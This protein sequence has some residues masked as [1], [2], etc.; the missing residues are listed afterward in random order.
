MLQVLDRRDLGSDPGSVNVVHV[1][2]NVDSN[3][4]EV[5][6]EGLLPIACWD[7]GFEIHWRHE[8]LFHVS[9]V[10]CQVE[11]SARGRSLDRGI[12]TDSFF[13][14]TKCCQEN[15]NLR[16]RWGPRAAEIRK[17]KML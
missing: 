6:G 12:Y 7:C 1:L 9:V 16:R 15:L 5:E 10:C 3:G 13:F 2:N 4:R 17:K 14:F 8:Y 11:V